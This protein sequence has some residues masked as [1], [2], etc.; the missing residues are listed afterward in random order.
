MREGTEPQSCTWR[1]RPTTARSSAA[2]NSYAPPGTSPGSGGP[3]GSSVGVH[4]RD[5]QHREE[6]SPAGRPLAEFSG[7]GGLPGTAAAEDHHAPHP[8]MMLDVR[9]TPAAELERAT[10]LGLLPCWAFLL[11][12]Q[13][14][15]ARRSSGSA[16]IA[17]T[18]PDAS[19]PRRTAARRAF[20]ELPPSLRVMPFDRRP[21]RRGW[22]GALTARDD[23]V[24]ART[25]PLGPV[26]V[27]PQ[28]SL[29]ALRALLARGMAT[30]HGP[31]VARRLPPFAV[32][33]HRR[34]GERR[35]STPAL[36]APQS[37]QCRQ[38]LSADPPSV[39][40]PS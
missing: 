18:L 29:P 19:H 16:H 4:R 9:A 30:P 5:R 22:A 27:R 21:G 33:R 15:K 25:G 37:N 12:W 24:T 10:R 20:P 31:T 11:D 28:V 14:A 13:P 32:T 1:T 40:R 35:E 3:S 23:E 36:L 17:C 26:S 38:S 8:Q 2:K 39:Q 34:A 7:K 6:R